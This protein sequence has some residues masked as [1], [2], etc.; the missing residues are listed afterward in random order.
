MS[1]DSAR[2]TVCVLVA[3]AIQLVVE[4]STFV[5]VH[6]SIVNK[7][8]TTESGPDKIIYPDS[9]PDITPGLP[10]DVSLFAFSTSAE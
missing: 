4:A 7:L 3:V 5:H 1:P 10:T 8:S 2:W 9:V 6:V